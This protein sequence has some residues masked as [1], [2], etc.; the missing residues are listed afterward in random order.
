MQ[1]SCTLKSIKQAFKTV[2]DSPLQFLR[3]NFLFLVIIV[4]IHF[5]SALLSMQITYERK[6]QEIIQVIFT[7]PV[8]S[9]F[10]GGYV[11]FYISFIQGITGRTAQILR[12]YRWYFSILAY[13]SLLYFFY[14]ILITPVV[15]IFDYS[16]LMQTRIIFGIL[17]YAWVFIRTSFF[18]AYIV[19]QNVKFKQALI[20][21]FIITKN[22]FWE[23]TQF[24][25]TGIFMLL[26]GT[27]GLIIGITYTGGPATLC[28]IYM[29]KLFYSTS[30]LQSSVNKK[31][32]V[33]KAEPN[34]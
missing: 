11:Y 16:L 27:A 1:E 25:V 20:N 33:S 5:L 9:Y 10:I 31:G 26:I 14:L 32:A 22:H 30:G 19:D 7:L 8:T 13:K 3:F 17:L 15:D 29:Y 6:W 23:T 24:L 18:L 28:Y 2:N 12:G 21:S 34:E 4:I